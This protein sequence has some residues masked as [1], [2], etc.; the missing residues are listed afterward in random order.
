MITIQFPDIV[1]SLANRAWVFAATQVAPIPRPR[2][3]PARVH[4]FRWYPSTEE[5]AIGILAGFFSK[6]QLAI[7]TKPDVPAPAIRREDVPMLA[8][9]LA[10][11]EV[12]R[13]GG[14]A[15][16]PPTIIAHHAA[17][18]LKREQR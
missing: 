14:A 2:P 12:A 4:S 5:R 8:P 9:A 15:V 16:A 17:S 1:I 13:V 10:K 18:G 7:Q 3:A 11:A 6:S